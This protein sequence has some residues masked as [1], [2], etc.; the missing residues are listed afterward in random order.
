MNFFKNSWIFKSKLSLTTF[1][2]GSSIVSYRVLMWRREMNL[3]HV[4]LDESIKIMEKHSKLI[5][6]L[7]YPLLID[8]KSDST[9]NLTGNLCY[10]KYRVKGPKGSL[11]AELG[12]QAKNHGEISGNYKNFI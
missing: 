6:L 12:G 11:I 10:F 3:N 2:F 5:E 9:I 1:V 4:V 7:G 8:R